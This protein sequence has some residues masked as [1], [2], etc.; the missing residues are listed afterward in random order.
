[1]SALD[2]VIKILDEGELLELV[3]FGNWGGGGKAEIKSGEPGC[4][5]SARP[6]RVH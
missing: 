2:D 3:V 6:L 5:E 1:M 4:L